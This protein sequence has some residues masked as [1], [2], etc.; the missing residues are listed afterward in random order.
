MMKNMV[1]YYSSK[2]KD[3]NQFPAKGACMHK[4]QLLFMPGL[5]SRNDPPK[6]AY[7]SDETDEAY[8]G[9]LSVCREQ[10]Y[11]VNN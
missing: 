2:M 8:W 9:F 11:S 10:I 5:I 7:R 6:N 4:I 3:K 1:E